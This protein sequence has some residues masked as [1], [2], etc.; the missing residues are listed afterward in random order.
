ML[1]L[2]IANKQKIIFSRCFNHA[3]PLCRKM[4]LFLKQWLHKCG[5]LGSRLITSYALTWCVIFYLQTLLVFPSISQLIKLKNSSWRIS[6][7]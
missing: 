4:I 2:C 1:Y 3:F 7:K 6:G 5:L